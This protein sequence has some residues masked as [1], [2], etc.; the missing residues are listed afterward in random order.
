MAWD[1]C[2][3]PVFCGD[4]IADPLAG[5]RGAVEVMHAVERGG[6][7]LIALAMAGVAAEFARETAEESSGDATTGPVLAP[8][9]P[10]ALPSSPGP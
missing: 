2:A 3:H 5:M 6:G 8:R 1:A 9:W 4:A 10:A 7:Q